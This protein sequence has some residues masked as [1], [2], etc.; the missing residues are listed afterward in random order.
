M[1]KSNGQP[2]RFA[3][4]IR[5]STEKQERQGES[6]RTQASQ[7]K[8]AVEALGGKIIATYAG[9]E[10]GTAGWE[11]K[12]LDKLLEDSAKKPRPFDA[13][14]VA[15]ASRWSRD[16]IRSETGLEVLRD[17]GVRFFALTTEYDL[18]NAEARLFLGLTATIGAYHARSQKEKSLLNRIERAK[19]GIPTGGKKPFGRMFDKATEKWEVIPEKQALIRDAAER[20]LAG[21][22]LQKLAREYGINHSNLVKVLRE[23]SGGDWSISFRADDLNINQTINISVPPL[24]PAKTIKALK[25]RLDANRTYLHGKPTFN[26]LLSG[27]VFCAECGYLM[28]GQANKRNQLYYRHANKDGSRDCEIPAPRPWVRAQM[29]EGVVLRDLFNL[30]G[31][32][33]AIKRAVKSAIPDGDKL[34]KRKLTL[35]AELTKIERARGRVLDHIIKDAITD[36]QAAPKLIQ[37]NKREN[38]L[39]IE[40]EKVLGSLGSSVDGD[41][42]SQAM[43]RV[44]KLCGAIVLYDDDGNTYAGGNDVQSFLMMTAA[45]KSALIDAAFGEPLDDGSPA[46]VYVKPAKSRRNGPKRFTYQLKGRLLGRVTQ[47]ASSWPSVNCHVPLNFKLCDETAGK[48]VANATPR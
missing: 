36:A 5:V 47:Y 11:R 48:G 20:Y 12:Q 45:D 25:S 41:D 29:I 40:L 30:F 34:S 44:M 38:E 39:R 8:Q 2:I 26:Y 37:L 23:R 9:Q 6:M 46:G 43:I 7:L 19:R 32:P 33:A 18:F 16:N 35:E 42:L 27:R 1:A 13:V 4:L 28:T 10:H 3:A 15:D 14:I 24:L 17:N 22:P 31:N 21:E